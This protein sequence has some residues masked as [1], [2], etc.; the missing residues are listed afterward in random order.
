MTAQARPS[1][2][3]GWAPI[4]GWFGVHV[5]T[6]KAWHRVRA[7]PISRDTPRQPP[8]ALPEDLERW[9]REGRRQG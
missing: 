8:R 7:L 9:V 4:A 5:D 3:I 6:L 2:L 1:V